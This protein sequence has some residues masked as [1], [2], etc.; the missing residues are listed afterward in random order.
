M[1]FCHNKVYAAL[2]K[3]QS[4][5]G[6]SYG[7]PESG[8][9]LEAPGIGV[10]NPCKDI[11]VITAELKVLQLCLWRQLGARGRIAY[12][13]EDCGD[14]PRHDQHLHDIA[15]CSHTEICKDCMSQLALLSEMSF[16]V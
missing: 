1:I 7:S 15:P 4:R 3:R 12:E 9:V 10:I 5:T 14:Q 16:V 2:S 11:L 13:E 6:G 8:E